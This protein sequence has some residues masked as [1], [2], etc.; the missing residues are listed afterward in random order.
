MKILRKRLIDLENATRIQTT[1]NRLLTGHINGT[2]N[3]LGKNNIEKY[4]RGELGDKHVLNDSFDDGRGVNRIHLEQEVKSNSP[5]TLLNSLE[6]K[7]QTGSVHLRGDTG[8]VEEIDNPDRLLRDRL[9]EHGVPDHEKIQ[10]T[11]NIQERADS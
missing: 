8:I 9:H 6:A 1:E 11:E 2:H 5:K 4:K 10:P 3:A 7:P